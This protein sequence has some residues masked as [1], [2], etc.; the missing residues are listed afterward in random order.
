MAVASLSAHL[1]FTVA[2]QRKTFAVC[3]N[4][5]AAKAL[6]VMQ[7]AGPSSPVL[8]RAIIC[9]KSSLADDYFAMTPRCGISGTP[10]IVHAATPLHMLH[11]ILKDGILDAVLPLF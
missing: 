1:W 4:I 11:I 7:S 9:E 6:F 8:K 3:S 10:K 5:K 2:C